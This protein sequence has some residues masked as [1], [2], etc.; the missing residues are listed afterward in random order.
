MKS[1]KICYILRGLSSSGKSFLANKI[2]VENSLA[3]IFSTDEFFMVDGSYEFNAAKLGD[4]HRW[5]QARF[6]LAIDLGVAT[7]IVDNTNC[8]LREMEPYVSYARLHDYQVI[9]VEPQTP[10]AWDR[11]ELVRRNKHGVSRE[12]LERQQRRYA[13]DLS[14]LG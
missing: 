10:W 14:S 13:R 11:D 3:E 12:V 5:N 6:R 8:S 9:F 2:Q 1:L 7:V 4:A